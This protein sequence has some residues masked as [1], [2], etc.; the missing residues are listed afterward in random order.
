MKK[1]I[2]FSRTSPLIVILIVLAG[3]AVFATRRE[4]TVDSW[5]PTHYSVNFT[6]NTELTA[7]Q[8]AHSEITLTTLKDKVST[9]DLDFGDMPVSAVTVNKKAAT[10]KQGSGL[11]LVNLPRAVSKG[12][13]LVIAVT[14]QGVP[15]AG[16]VISRDKSGHPSV[17]GDN[18]PNNVHHWIPSLDHPSAKATVAFTIT[19]PD[20][21]VIVANGKFI[22]ITNQFPGM[23]T[24][25]YS[26]QVP[27]PPYCMI[28]AAGQ[29]AKGS[30]PSSLTTLEYYVPLADQQAAVKGFSSA[31][32]SL[33][34]FSDLVA[35]YPYEKLALIVGATQFGGMENSSAIV[36][37][38]SL[39]NEVPNS[40]MSPSF[41]IR[42]G[43]VQ[44]VAHEIAH[45][46]F[47]DS[48]TQDTWSDLW[49]SE[50]FATYFAG[51]V[52][53]K[54]DGEAAFRTYM[55]TNAD[56]YFGFAKQKR[57]PLKDTETEDLLDL[58]NGN[59]YQKGA[60][61]LHMLRSQLGDEAFFR[62]IKT[63]Y[64]AHKNGTAN[65]ED[66]RRHLEKA[67]GAD[68]KAFFAS[69]VY[70]AGHPDYDITW[71]WNSESRSLR[72]SVKQTQPEAAFP[73]WLPIE[74]VTPGG[75]QRFVIKPHSKEAVAV[76]PL[77]EQPTELL[78]DPDETVLKSIRVSR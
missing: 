37:R 13:Q 67:S 72:V 18:W 57:I 76:F 42:R 4:R 53:Q 23:R 25:S 19:A 17:V 47:G 46:W 51:L 65:S 71:S 3:P 12:T 36:F 20:K 54:H 55:K 78:V 5:K 64:A 50:G 70:G 68:L 59:A 43:L 52:L 40:N 7:I 60:W 48:V 34:L 10:F 75:K 30:L 61:V 74:A 45:Q 28:F 9:I 73:N 11:L 1:L 31:D 77:K 32:P 15:K 33:K 66:L 14:Y 22:S 56:S 38:S 44:L 35:P 39:F 69:W 2:R 6:L 62:G 21:N 27:I 26:E 41:G 63:F 8:K 58:L 29:F 16:L 49:L 24:W